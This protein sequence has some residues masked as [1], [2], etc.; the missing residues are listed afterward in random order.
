MGYRAPPMDAEDRQLTPR[1]EERRRQLM[2]FAAQRF[3][4]NGYHPTSVAE[5]VEGLGVGKG[6]FYWYF[7]S[8]DDL[9]TAIL[10]DGQRELRR[11]QRDAIAEAATPLERVRRGV[12]ASIEWSLE[13]PVL[14]RLFQFAATDERFAGRLRTGEEI[15]VADAARHI[16]DAIDAGEIPDAD[17]TVLAHA[18]LGVHTRLVH[19]VTTGQVERNDQIIDTAVDFCVNGIS[20]PHAT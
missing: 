16:Q 18:M 10:S 7:D 1:G 14:F 9:L 13:Q 17:A 5:I 2:E 3:A 12:R 15:A 19:L 11:R 4:E 6:V 20:G 8:K